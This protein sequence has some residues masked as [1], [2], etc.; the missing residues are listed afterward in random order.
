VYP[1]KTTNS[2]EKRDHKENEDKKDE[3]TAVISMALDV[4]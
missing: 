3:N 2:E 1:P 4:F